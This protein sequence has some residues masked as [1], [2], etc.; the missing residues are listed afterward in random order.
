M[1]GEPCQYFVKSVD[2]SGRSIRAVA[3]RGGLAITRK[4]EAVTVHPR[5]T[6][7][8]NAAING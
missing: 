5:S 2:L 3:A 8:C 6:V 1:G 7:D 4:T